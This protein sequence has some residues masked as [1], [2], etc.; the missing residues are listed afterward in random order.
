MNLLTIK[1]FFVLSITPIFLSS[2]YIIWKK[3]FTSGPENATLTCKA[4]NA[5]I[6]LPKNQKE[7][8]F[9]KQII[10]KMRRRFGFKFF[11]LTIMI[12]ASWNSNWIN[13]ENR[14]PLAFTPW[15]SGNPR[16]NPKCIF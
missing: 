11:Q 10:N 3:D 7:N 1:I 12:G 16:G 4:Q 8:D 15:C 13:M 14:E 2:R 5:Q 9:M 6:L